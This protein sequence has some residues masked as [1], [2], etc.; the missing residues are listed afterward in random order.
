MSNHPLIDNRSLCERQA[1]FCA[2]FTNPE[3]IRIILLLGKKEM[4]V[5]ELAQNLDI[6][7]P[8]LSQHLR[9][10][11]DR[12]CLTSRKEGKNV[13]YRITSPLFLDAMNLVRKG[14]TEAE[15]IR[16]K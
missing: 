14:I 13:Y 6:S 9:L 8:N 10:M 4:S 11:K 16:Y 12:L 7:L 2:V 3:R 1:E 5:G 15:S